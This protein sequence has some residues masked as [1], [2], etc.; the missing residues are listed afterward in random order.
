MKLDTGTLAY[1]TARQKQLWEQAEYLLEREKKEVI[2]PLLVDYG[3]LVFSAAKVY[4]G[5]LKSFLYQMGFISK[6]GYYDEH[7][8]IGKALNPDLPRRF[9]DEEWVFDDVAQLCG[10]PVADLL[11]ETWRIARNKVFHYAAQNQ[12]RLT[13]HEAELTVARVSEAMRA[14]SGCEIKLKQR[15]EVR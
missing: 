10:K 3:F 13:L 6:A 11:W 12:E 5:F 1:L 14:A 7:F 9:R 15:E 4:E 2:H 8:R